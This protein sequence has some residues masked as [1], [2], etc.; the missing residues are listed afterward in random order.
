MVLQQCQDNIKDVLNS[1]NS[2]LKYTG[3]T[4]RQVLYWLA[5]KESEF[6]L[7]SPKLLKRLTKYE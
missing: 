1:R 6:K 5:I 7:F 4:E 2:Y 3:P